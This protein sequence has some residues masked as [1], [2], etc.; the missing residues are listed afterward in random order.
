MKRQ[1]VLI[2]HYIMGEIVNNSDYKYIKYENKI[3]ELIKEV[4]DIKNEFKRLTYDLG[5]LIDTK[6][7]EDKYECDVKR[8]FYNEKE[9]LMYIL[10]YDINNFLKQDKTI[11]I[12][13]RVDLNGWSVYSFIRKEKDLEFLKKHFTQNGINYTVDIKQNKLKIFEFDINEG[14]DKIAQEI[15]VLFDKI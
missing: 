15:K 1:N 3:N 12:D 8:W 5:N 4:N 2:M 11:A 10:V 14:L 6:N 13:I 9:E 7:L